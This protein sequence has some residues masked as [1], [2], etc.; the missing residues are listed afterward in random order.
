MKIIELTDEMD[1]LLG[2]ICD[3]AV[4]AHGLKSIDLIQ[5]LR[6][7]IKEISHMKP[8]ERDNIIT[9]DVVEYDF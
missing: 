9:S 6:S 5:K 1:K 3:M 2:E 8:E 7:S 4:K